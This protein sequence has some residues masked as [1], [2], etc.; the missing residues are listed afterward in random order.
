MGE[1]KNEGRQQEVGASRSFKN[2]M[3]LYV[4][5]NRISPEASRKGNGRNSK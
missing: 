2:M 3:F 4:L 5:A 1:S